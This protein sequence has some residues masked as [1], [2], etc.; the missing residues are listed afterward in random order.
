MGALS[1]WFDTGNYVADT[2]RQAEILGAP[3]TP[4]DAISRFATSL[5]HHSHQ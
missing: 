5:G 1:A 4:E 2:T 3:P